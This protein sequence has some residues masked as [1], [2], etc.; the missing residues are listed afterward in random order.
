MG[1][2]APA[3]ERTRTKALAAK[4]PT[5]FL[6]GVFSAALEHGLKK[7]VECTTTTASRHTCL[8]PRIE[9]GLITAVWDVG[10]K[11]ETVELAPS[12]LGVP[13]RHFPVLAVL[14]LE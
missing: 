3:Q 7:A 5:I 10:Q 8:L 9:H 11:S 1:P 4:S 13:P 6:V 2:R 12:L 14:S